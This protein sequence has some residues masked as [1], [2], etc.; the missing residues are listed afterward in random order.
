ME[1][2]HPTSRASRAQRNEPGRMPRL[3]IPR[4]FHHIWF[5]SDS[6]PDEVERLRKTWR[7]NHPE[8]EFRLWRETDLGWL[9]NEV[10]FDRASSYAQKADIARYEIIHRFG[11]VYLDA[12]M[13]SLKPI[14]GLIDGLDFFAGR[15]GDGFVAIGIF[16]APPR[17]ALLNE[18]ITQLPVSCLL[19]RRCSIAMQTGPGL[20]TR[21]LQG[22]RWEGRGMN[23]RIFPQPFFYPYDSAEPWRRDE[24]FPTAYA[25]HHWSYSWKGQESVSV[26]A[27]D[28]V[29]AG[30]RS[31]GVCGSALVSG[32]LAK[33]FHPMRRRAEHSVKRQA[34]RVIRRVS[35][36]VPRAVATPPPR[37]VPWGEGQVL[38]STPFQTRLLCPTDDLSISPE[39]ALYG[40]YDRPFIDVLARELQPGMTFVDVGANIGLFT[41]VAAARVGRG[42][43]VFAYECNPELVRVLERNVQ[44]NW[45]GD[46]IRVVPKAAH[47]D[48]ERREFIVPRELKMLGSLTRHEGRATDGERLQ[49][50]EVSCEPLD[51]GLADVRFIDVLKIDVEGG[52]AA[53][54]N[55]ARGL[56]RAGRIRTIS[57]EYRDNALREDLRDEM[58]STLQAIVTEHGARFEVPGDARPIPLDEV[59]TV[60]DYSQLL[61]RFPNSRN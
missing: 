54:L 51:E 60:F 26:S 57:L 38:V 3:E 24:R 46:R 42:G 56:I 25:A 20:L 33:G 39:L 41:I 48:R 61:I 29:D 27:W 28:L 18:I 37:A 21:C 2:S 30:R 47:R 9:R 36:Q 58:E 17:N 34:A 44:M 11:G 59:L 15:E 13:E 45:F 49:R 23:L 12:D 5:G 7:A 16:G 8:W 10:L 22:G 32:I 1:T 35:A 4:V 43:R 31:P 6:L 53:V 40:T 50:F 55:G 19:N 52:E 14:D